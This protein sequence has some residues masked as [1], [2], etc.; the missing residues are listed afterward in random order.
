MGIDG[1]LS[2]YTLTGVPVYDQVIKRAAGALPA[3]KRC[4]LLDLQA[5]T[6]WPRWLVKCGVLL[7][8]PLGEA[9]V[10][11]QRH[12][13]ESMQRYFTHVRRT[14]VDFGAAYIATGESTRRRQAM[15]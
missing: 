2:T 11:P 8:R 1:V 14:D 3:G 12:P 9:L 15:P 4:V 10:L 5:P 7:T 13:W 6:H